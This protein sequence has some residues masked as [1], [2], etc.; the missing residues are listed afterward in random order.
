MA[1]Q[2][3]A[4]S[5]KVFLVAEQRPAEQDQ[6]GVQKADHVGQRNAQVEHGVAQDLADCRVAL[7]LGGQHL[8]QRQGL[9][10]GAKLRQHGAA[11]FPQ[12]AP[13][14]DQ[15]RP[16]AGKRLQAAGVSAVVPVGAARVQDHFADLAGRGF[17][18]AEG[19]VPQHH[20][21]GDAPRHMAEGK[22]ALV[23]QQAGPEQRHRTGP[24]P[25]VVLQPHRQMDG[26]AD[27][28]AQRL[29]A[30]AD[31]LAAVVFD[32]A[33]VRVDDAGDGDPY[34]DQQVPLGRVALFQRVQNAQQLADHGV[35]VLRHQVKGALGPHAAPQVGDAVMGVVTPQRDAQRQPRSRHQVDVDGLSAHPV[36]RGAGRSRQ[37]LHHALLDQFGDDVGDGGRRQ[38]QPLGDLRTGQW[39]I[40]VESRLDGFEILLLDF[41]K[42][43][44]VHYGHMCSPHFLLIFAGCAEIK[45]VKIIKFLCF[46]IIISYFTSFVRTHARGK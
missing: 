2:R 25:D 43:F 10:V 8:L 30:P 23:P 14:L 45:F 33:G 1:V 3:A 11:A 20:R 6:M 18:A 7:G 32:H 5:V 41:G 9:R 22:G 24:G 34:A 17:L 15:D 40:A 13:A 42:V 19:A 36:G 39:G 44:A 26:L 21:A 28:G 16:H 35:V 37:L 29:A 12:R 27:G 38:R 46:S 31:A 4:D